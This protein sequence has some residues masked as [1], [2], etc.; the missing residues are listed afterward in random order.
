M[1]IIKQEQNLKK[2]AGNFDASHDQRRSEGGKRITGDGQPGYEQPAGS[3][4]PR[5]P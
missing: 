5:Y 3:G 2:R 1:L 4:F